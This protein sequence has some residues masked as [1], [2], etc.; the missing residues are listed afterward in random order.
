[1]VGLVGLCGLAGGLVGWFVCPALG[2]MCGTQIVTV[3]VCNLGTHDKVFVLC[4]PGVPCSIIAV[5]DELL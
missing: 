2:V 3:V 5:Y 1:M 4:R